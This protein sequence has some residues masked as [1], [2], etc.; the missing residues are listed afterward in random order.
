M[1]TITLGNDAI[2]WRAIV[3][4]ACHGA[5]L[6]LSEERWKRVRDVRRAVEEFARGETRYYGINTGLGA[7]CH[8]RLAPDQ[9]QR[10]SYH[11]LMSHACCVGAPLRDDQVRAIMAT[12]VVN[13]SHGHSGISPQIV[14]RLLDFL[15]HGVTPVVPGQGSV[16]YLTHMAHIGLAMIGIGEVRHEGKIVSAEAALARIGKPPVTLGAKDGLSLVNGTPAMTGLACLALDG[17]NRLSAWA[18]VGAAMSFDALGGQLEA[19][20]ADVLALKPQLGMQI[21]GR[22]LREL[23]HDSQWLATRRGGHL[24]DAL[25]LRAIPQVHGACRDQLAHAAQQVDREL[26]SATDNPLLLKNAEGYRVV[27]Q[28]NPHGESIA[29]ACD[30]LAMAVAEWSAIS[31]RRIYRLVTPEVSSLHSGLP[32]FLSSESGMK[33]GMMIA[34]YTAASLAAD[35]KR[36]AQP[37]VIDNYLTSALQEDHLSLGDSAALK[38]DAAIDN[39]FRIIAIEWLCAAQAFDLLPSE[40]FATGTSAAWGWLRGIVGIYGEEH[41]LSMDIEMIYAAIRRA[42]IP[43][44][45]VSTLGGSPEARALTLT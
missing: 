35:N 40:R 16:G 32:P 24:Q 18:D 29:L 4:V 21:C 37:A 8:V 13:Y 1:T 7:L 44:V 34:Q 41:P 25:S 27:S 43:P 11:T 2:S 12:A 36:L 14:E 22:T 19:F 9:L 28:A 39:A 26:N 45:L 23:L 5:E 10:L 33:S 15:N 38:L 30:Q 6:Q 17:A 31:E 3:D 42:S 20:D